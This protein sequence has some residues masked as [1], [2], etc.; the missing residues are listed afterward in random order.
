MHTG[1]SSL[2]KGGLAVLVTDPFG[3]AMS[4]LRDLLLFFQGT[5]QAL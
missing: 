2:A 4:C 1:T 3:N 5:S